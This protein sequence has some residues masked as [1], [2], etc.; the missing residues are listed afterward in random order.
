MNRPWKCR[1]WPSAG[2]VVHFF[3][4]PGTSPVRAQQAE[5][6]TTNGV[7][8]CFPPEP[9]SYLWTRALMSAPR[10]QRESRDE[11]QGWRSG[12]LH[13]KGKGD[14]R[15]QRAG[16]WLCLSVLKMQGSNF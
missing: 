8:E 11:E 4:Y 10:A 12:T 5:A 1:L 3:L 13:R 7:Q 16:R 6:V 9:G 15:R 14:Y 2:W